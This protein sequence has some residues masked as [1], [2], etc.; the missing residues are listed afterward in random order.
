MFCTSLAAKRKCDG[1]AYTNSDTNANS[2]IVRHYAYCRP[3]TSS[4][5]N[6]CADADRQRLSKRK[7]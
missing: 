7:S 4:D 3:D 2:Y 5:T 1:Y 6:A